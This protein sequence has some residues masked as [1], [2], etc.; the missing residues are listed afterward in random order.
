MPRLVV[1]PDSPEAWSI[2]LHPGEITLG[3]SPQNDFPLEHSSVSSVHCRITVSDKGVWLKDLGSTAGTF[4]NDELVEQARLQ[5]GQ[6]LRL[7][8]IAMRFESEA[9]EREAPPVAPPLPS[10]TATLSVAAAG[11]RCKFHPRILACFACPQCRQTFCELCVTSRLVNDISRQFCRHCGSECQ[12]LQP[13]QPRL[14]QPKPPPGF[15]ASLPRALLYPFQGNGYILLIAGTAFFYLLGSLPLIGLLLGGYLFAYAKSIIT[16]TAAGDKDP[17]DWPDFSN[18]KDD[19][20]VPYLQMGALVVFFFGPAFLISRWHPGTE[21]TARVAYLAALGFGVLFAPMG[22]LALAMFD[23]LT[24]LNPIALISCILRVPL[25]YL[26]AAAAF[27]TVLLLYWFAAGALQE[28]VPVPFV[29][30]LISGLLNL[31]VLS[32]AMRI[33]GLLYATNQD[34]FGWFARLGHRSGA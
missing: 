28:L 26:V 14:E 17:P 1:N 32:V 3:R 2:D 18:W 22:M 15:L 5:P 29:P 24:V 20:L 10:P 27:E 31:Y 12:P 25:H 11:A 30:S 4:V 7:G 9:P 6:I 21:N 8:D 23:T 33:L 13:I 19:M 16:S 34:K